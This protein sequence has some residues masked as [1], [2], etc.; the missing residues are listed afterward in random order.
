M[1]GWGRA[2][3]MNGSAALAGG[4][5]PPTPDGAPPSPWRSDP[6]QASLPARKSVRS[7][8][9]LAPRKRSVSRAVDARTSPRNNLLCAESS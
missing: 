8:M 4:G 6:G 5:S 2:K 7:A 9:R 1:S 3:L